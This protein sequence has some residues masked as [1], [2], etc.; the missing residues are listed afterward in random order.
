MQFLKSHGRRIAGFVMTLVVFALVLPRMQAD[1]AVDAEITARVAAREAA[2][3]VAEA[4]PDGLEVHYQGAPELKTA[5]LEELGRGRNLSESPNGPISV[6]STL[7]D[8][9]VGLKVSAPAMDSASEV[10]K[11]RGH[12]TSVLPALLA[13]LI[14]IFFRS[15]VP[16]LLAAVWIGGWLAADTALAGTYKGAVFVGSSLTGAF[17]LYIIGFTIALVGMVQVVTRAGGVRGV[18][19]VVTRYARTKRTTRAATALM[20]LAIFF[21]DYANTIVVGTTMR[22]VTDAQRISREKLAYIVDSTSAPIAGLAV[23][24][25][26]IGYEVGIFDELSRQLSLGASGYDI[27]FEIMPLRFYCLTTLMFVMVNALWGRDFGPMLTAERRAESGQVLREG[28][29]PLASAGHTVTEPI[30]GKPHRWYNAVGPVSFVLLCVFLTMWWSGWSH[31][32]LSIPNL[33]DAPGQ[34]ASMFIASLSDMGSAD[35][36]RD[37]FSNADNAKALFWSSVLGSLL[38]IGLAVG[39]RILTVVDAAK[40]WAAALPAMWLAIVILVLAWSLRAVCDDL[41]TSIYLMGAVQD[42]ITPMAL[43]IITFLLASVV[44]FATGT[45]WGTMGILL[46]AII[47]LAVL[48]CAGEPNGH[49]LIMLCFGAV[50]DGAIFGDHCSPISDTTVMSSIASGSDHLDHVRTQMPY[51]VV[52]M[53]IASCV[54]YL[55]VA[56]GEPIWLAHAAALGLVVAV[57]GVVGRP[58]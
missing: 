43:P 48:A 22:P 18:L 37:A 5:I 20:G 55:G 30:E 56:A 8:S 45:S 16:A 17:N 35:A 3:A 29:K 33:M 53:L 13:V 31:G 36:W 46:P 23:I 21:D 24:S 54:G 38:A 6:T 32:D 14:A 25:T 58:H 27:F 47:P 40:T 51:A 7:D 1:P 19:S 42:L 26:W 4:Y 12:W 52:T 49:L 34:V 57:M 10:T 15:L 50:L 28:A 41:G 9:F 44:A 11:R 2:T 39:Q